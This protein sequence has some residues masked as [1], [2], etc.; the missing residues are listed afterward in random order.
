MIFLFLP[1]MAMV[2]HVFIRAAIS[3][4]VYERA[5]TP[6]RALIFGI[7]VK[8]RFS[9]EILP[10]MR[11]DAL[12]S[13]MIR[14]V[15]RAPNRF[16]M[17]HIKIWIFGK[18]IYKL[19]WYFRFWMSKWTKVSILAFDYFAFKS[20]NVGSAKFGFIFIRMVKLFDPIMSF[21]TRVSI[22]AFFVF[23]NEVTHF[24]LIGS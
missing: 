6:I 19:D 3:I 11:K 24:R 17:E 23:E 21:L 5:R 22:F 2:A 14:L 20:W 4:I 15:V 9:S 7:V 10:V 16:K 18:L 13:L 8:L 1:S 12:I